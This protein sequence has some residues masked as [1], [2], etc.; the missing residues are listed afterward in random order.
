MQIHQGVGLAQ[1]TLSLDDAALARA[2]QVLETE[3]ATALAVARG[4][5]KSSPE[6][7]VAQLV[8]GIAQRRQNEPTAALETLARL[9]RAQPRAGAAH[10]EYGLA[11]SAA[12]QGEA[13]VSAL[14]HAVRL[15]PD[16]PGA[17]RALAD[18]LTAIGDSKAADAAYA[19]HIKAA[20]Q[21]PRLLRAGAAL[22][23]NDIPGAENLLR[24]HLREHPT[25]VAAIRMFAEVA[26]RL[27]RLT[28][29]TSLLE[30]CL[31]LAPGFFEA[32]ANYATVLSRQNRPMD[33]LREIDALL[34]R[35][36]R[37]SHYRN[38][39]ATALV[40]IGEYEGAIEILTALV[41]EYPHQARVWLNYGHV[42]K[43]AGRQDEAVR[44][45]RKCLQLAPQASE[46]W[47][48]LA[49][50]K[51]LRF[52]AEDVAAMQAALARPEA[53]TDDR[54]HLNF[55][56]GKAREDSAI[57]DESFAY[58]SA[59]NALR[60][61]QIQYRAEETTAAVEQS[62]ALFTR[63]FFDTR[64]GSGAPAPDPIFIVGLPRAGSTLIDQIL[65]NH[66]Q[67]EGTMELYDMIDLARESGKVLPNLPDSELRSLGERYL[68]RTRIQ[69]KTGTPYFID[70]M[71]N[72]FLHAGLIA[73]ILPNAKIIDARRHP[74]ACGFSVYK[75]HFARGQHF[76]YDLADIGRYYRDYVDLMAHFD[77]IL[78]GRVHRVHHEALVEDTENEVRRLL[79]YCGLPYEAS[80]LR[81]YENER[82]VR[83]ASSEQVRRPIFRD[84]LEQWRHYQPWLEPLNAALGPV[85]ETYP[86]GPNS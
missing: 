42:L 81:F 55:A 57:Y 48:T 44:A 58:Y 11:L 27:G 76:S 32:R 66:S 6:H 34:V 72:N 69:R 50:L 53:T 23:A 59:G 60:R 33:T 71:P 28:D 54:V 14:Q 75:Q 52:S 86:H 67:V 19:Q 61:G 68:Q 35:E 39:K 31:E 56:L 21:N 36:P 24:A 37:N 10:Y 83:T 22:C 80:C 8:V 17:W 78:P 5:L 7:P 30:R 70:K 51:T 74:L 63:Q 38:L 4:V 84:G 65:S 64:Q 2:L 16:L 15:S 85:V 45:Y 41:A 49:N 18:H 77:E 9:V 79:E 47:F 26:A 73:T 29:A 40:T 12:G 1:A 62:R 46:A 3:P 13:A 20:C 25:D 82:P 43:T